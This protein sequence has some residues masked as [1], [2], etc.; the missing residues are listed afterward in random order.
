MQ[1]CFLQYRCGKI[2]LNSFIV[3]A[4]LLDPRFK[5]VLINPEQ[6]L[7]CKNKMINEILSLNQLNEV[8]EVIDIPEDTDINDSTASTITVNTDSRENMDFNVECTSVWS[9]VDTKIKE[10]NSRKEEN[11]ETLNIK[12]EKEIKMYFDNCL[13]DREKD[14]LDWWTEIGKN[15][16]PNLKGLVGKYLVIPATSVP[17]ERIFSKSGQVLNNKRTLLKPNVVNKVVFLNSNLN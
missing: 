12:I 15:L 8:E 2:E 3:I 4:T 11:V 17:S 14:P 5:N 13:L 16:Y 1:F 10:H 9:Y 7:R 6:F